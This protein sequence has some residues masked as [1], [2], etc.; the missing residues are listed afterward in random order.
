[1]LR[2]IGVPFSIAL[3]ALLPV[4]AVARNVLYVPSERYISL[5]RA[6]SYRFAQA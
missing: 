3:R 4:L 1:M 5:S 6:E 2:A